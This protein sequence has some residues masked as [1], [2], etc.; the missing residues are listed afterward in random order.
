[1]V[2]P[3]RFA[4]QRD[5]SEVF[6][7]LVRFIFRERMA[8]SNGG[9]GCRAHDQLARLQLDRHF[10]AD[11]FKSQRLTHRHWLFRRARLV[12]DR[13]IIAPPLFRLKKTAKQLFFQLRQSF[14]NFFAH[15]CSS[16]VKNLLFCTKYKPLVRWFSFIFYH[17]Q[18][19]EEYP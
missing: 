15:L 2:S 12:E 13:Q 8:K 1:M 5:L 16:C 18:I 14:G 6:R 10:L 4:V 9:H 3:D 11:L 17:C 19:T 7:F